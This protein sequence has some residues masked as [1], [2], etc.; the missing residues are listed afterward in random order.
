[1]SLR[2]AAFFISAFIIAV[3]AFAGEC[4]SSGDRAAI[5]AVKAQ[6]DRFN[7]AIAEKDL[8]VVEAVLKENVQ[9][10]TG[11]NSD[12]FEGRD[13][14]LALWG[15]DFQSPER[16]I[17]VRTPH[18]IRVSNVVPVAL[19]QGRWRGERARDGASFAAGSYAAKWRLTEGA[20]RIEAEIF[21]TEACGGDFCPKESGGE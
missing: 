19:E 13:A 2:A 5:D 12:L 10:V 21:A 9:L 17:Y 11:T 1:M 14:Q 18:C 8:P 16:A 6:R 7:Q 20:W 4:K 15:D 3:P